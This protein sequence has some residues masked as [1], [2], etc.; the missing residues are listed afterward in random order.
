VSGVAEDLFSCPASTIL[1]FHITAMRSETCAADTQIVGNE[2]HGQAEPLPQAGEQG[3]DLGLDRDVEG[4]HWLVG[5]Q[6][7]GLERERPRKADA[8]ALPAENSCG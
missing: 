5:D 4:R 8:L 1:P 2:D 7:V 6:D 3:E